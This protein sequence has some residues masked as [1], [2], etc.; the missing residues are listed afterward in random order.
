MY[1]IATTLLGKM[2]AEG[3]SAVFNSREQRTSKVLRPPSTG[4]QSL[5][6]RIC[7]IVDCRRFYFLLLCLCLAAIAMR[8]PKES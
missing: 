5:H 8:K 6:L 7:S 1:D 2:E 3:R 4:Q